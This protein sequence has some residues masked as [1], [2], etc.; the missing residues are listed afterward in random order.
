MKEILIAISFLSL[1][2]GEPNHNISHFQTKNQWLGSEPAKTEEILEAEKR[3]NVK[4]P[5]DYKNFLKITNG[6]LA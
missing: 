1:E 2:L 4:L 3:L 6:F 5:S